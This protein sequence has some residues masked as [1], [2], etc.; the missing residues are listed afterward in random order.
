MRLLTLH[1]LTYMRELVAGARGAIV[2]GELRRATGRGSSP[3]ARPSRRLAPLIR[4]LLG[5]RVLELF[6]DLVD[7]VAGDLA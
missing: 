2:A 7:R 3:A 4:V 1:N 5:D 6:D